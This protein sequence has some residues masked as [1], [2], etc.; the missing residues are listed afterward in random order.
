MEQQ[1][2]FCTTPE[3]V[4]LAYSTVGEGPLLLIPPYWVSHVEVQWEDP[5]FRDFIE[6]LAASH[7]IVR[8]D[9]HGC[10]LSDRERTDFTLE[11]ELR[12][13]EAIV[14]HLGVDRF[15]FLGISMGGPISIAYAV[16][17][18][19]RITHLVLYGTYGR[20]SASAPIENIPPLCALIRTS[21]GLGSRTLADIFVPDGDA[22][23]LKYFARW[24][25]ES[26][27]A[28]TAARLLESLVAE[29]DVTEDLER[30]TT[31]TIVIHRKGDRA[32]SVRG[33]RELA[34]SI[35]GARLVLLEG[36]QHAA[37]YGNS[38]EVLSIILAFLA[39]GDVS[40]AVQ[41]AEKRTEAGTLTRRLA[42][43]V[44]GDVVG[45]SRLMEDDE[46]ATVQAVNACRET[47]TALL[48][49][50]RGRLVD[51]TGDSFLG[52]FSSVV[53]AVKCAV[54]IQRVLA[55]QNAA[56]PADRRMELRI[57]V[58]LGD[59]IEEGERIYGDG[60][61]IAA[62]LESLADP[63]GVCISGSVYDQIESKLP[64][65]F[66]FAGEQSVKN[67][68]RPVRVYRVENL[69]HREDA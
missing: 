23:R 26:A 1:I 32:C 46:T 37:W 16:K 5:D 61:N 49:E 29:L 14:E 2:Q 58:N 35:P 63:G 57:G 17:Y 55:E 21:W 52:E 64:L 54:E 41:Q 53:N 47:V 8:Y 40:E 20:G 62:R 39:T 28:E 4:H 34:T 27:T 30:V 65:D 15:A 67:I 50:H 66:V 22:A 12:D 36:K 51:A 59:V 3:G 48:G 18:P 10:G 42:A 56:L 43:I 6:K 45:Y 19:Q 11:K 44:C 38:G 60:V 9:R 24:Q 13:L 68:S 31:P 7:R 33:G 69:S 25:K